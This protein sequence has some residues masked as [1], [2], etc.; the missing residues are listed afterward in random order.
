VSDEE[1]IE[2]LDPETGEYYKVKAI[3]AT[4]EAAEALGYMP[5]SNDDWLRSAEI[6]DRV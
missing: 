6:M 4:I 2:Y 5:A 3:K 1:Y